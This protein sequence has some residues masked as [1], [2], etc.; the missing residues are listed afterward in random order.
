MVVNHRI[1]DHLQV[2]TLTWL[3]PVVQ[4]SKRIYEAEPHIFSSNNLLSDSKIKRNLPQISPQ[5]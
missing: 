5:I 1:N 4:Y 2:N 3:V